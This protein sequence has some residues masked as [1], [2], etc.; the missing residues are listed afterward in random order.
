MKTSSRAGQVLRS[1]R[2]LV[3]CAQMACRRISGRQNKQICGDLFPDWDQQRAEA[4]A[5]KKEVAR[6]L[7]AALTLS[8]TASGPARRGHV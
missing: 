6:Q 2:V 8:N 1:D 4:F 3:S 7:L 5:E